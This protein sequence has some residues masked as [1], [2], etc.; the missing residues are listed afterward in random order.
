MEACFRAGK[1]VRKRSLRS[2]SRCRFP[3][4]SFDVVLCDNVVDHAESPAK[5]V[6]ELARIWF[7]AD[8]CISQ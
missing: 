6:S 8:Y 2:A 4:E 5:I 1:A 3:I 7:R